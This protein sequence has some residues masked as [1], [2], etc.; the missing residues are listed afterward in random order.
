MWFKFLIFPWE[1]SKKNW[2]LN[3]RRAFSLSLKASL[4]FKRCTPCLRVPICAYHTVNRSRI[5][6]DAKPHS[7]TTEQSGSKADLTLRKINTHTVWIGQIQEAK[8]H[9]YIF[10]MRMTVFYWKPSS[11]NGILGG[12]GVMYFTG[13]CVRLQL[14]FTARRLFYSPPQMTNADSLQLPMTTVKSCFLQ[15]NFE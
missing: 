4:H 9:K 1:W 8:P 3:I 5:K 13:G 14:C 6:K 7:L 12:P 15:S 10:F 2:P 11:L